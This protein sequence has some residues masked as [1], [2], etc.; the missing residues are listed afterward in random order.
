MPLPPV[1]PG[2]PRVAPP[3]GAQPPTSGARLPPPPMLSKRPTDGA[4]RS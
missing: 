4:L 3:P 2:L 1:V